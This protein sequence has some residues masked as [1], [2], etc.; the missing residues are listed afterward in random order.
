MRHRTPAF[1]TCS[2]ATPLLPHPCLVL[3]GQ[4]NRST[5]RWQHIC[6]YARCWVLR[7]DSTAAF[8]QPTPQ[9]AQSHRPRLMTPL[10]HTFLP[11][12]FPPL[13]VDVFEKNIWSSGEYVHNHFI[14]GRDKALY[15]C[16]DRIND[17]EV[18]PHRHLLNPP[19]YI[20]Y[21]P[22]CCYKDLHA[23]GV[24]PAHPSVRSRRKST[25]SGGTAQVLFSRLGA[26]LTQPL[27]GVPRLTHRRPC[28]WSRCTTRRR[29]GPC[30]P[31]RTATC[32]CSRAT[33][34]ATRRPRPPRPCRCSTWWTAT[35]RSTASRRPRR[36][37]TAQTTVG[38]RTKGGMIPNPSLD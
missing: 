32:A 35:T 18:W 23:P 5:G 8:P 30:W 36:C 1:P 9:P 37:C 6:R 29:C 24:P 12:L 16:P 26:A 7:P 3:L 22:R 28:R 13:Q 31:A 4:D 17:A 33:R 38:T 14:E 10:S 2:R 20:H 34:C 21:T 25:T 15:L 19:L 11:P 27:L